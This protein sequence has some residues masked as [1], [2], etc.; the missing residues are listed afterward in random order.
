MKPQRIEIEIEPTGQVR[1]DA[2][3]YAG[4]DCEQVTAF[5]EA[6]LGEVTA[7]QRKPEYY[8]ANLARL[9]QRVGR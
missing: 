2:V 9:V 7:K 3:N 4:P 1:L 8:R 5:L 6:A